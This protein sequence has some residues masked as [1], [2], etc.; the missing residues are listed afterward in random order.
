MTYYVFMLL[1]V[2]FIGEIF[3]H[4]QKKAWK[5]FIKST[6]LLIVSMLIILGTKLSW[7]EMNRN[8]LKET[9]RG[10]HSELVSD[11]GNDEK[12]VGLDF[13]Y[14]TA[15][16]YGKAETLTLLIPD[17]MGGASNYNLG[18]DSKL[19]KELKNIGK[20][21]PTEKKSVASVEENT[22][23]EEASPAAEEAAP[24]SEP[25]PAPETGAESSDNKGGESA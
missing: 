2:M 17:Y 3:I 9:M 15:W 6:A 8:Y 23:A 24:V 13:D 11:E 7:L 10:G 16:S 12:L 14:A 19:E 1:G 4:A 22:P 25:A 18:K 20:T 5:E 21:K